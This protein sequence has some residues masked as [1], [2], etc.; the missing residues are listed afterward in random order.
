[1]GGSFSL[2]GQ[3]AIVTGASSGLGAMMAHGLA[4]AGCAVLL[5]ARRQNELAAWRPRSRR[6]RA[7]HRPS[8]RPARP[9][10][11]PGA[12][13]R[14][15]GAFGRLDGVVLN[16]ATSASPRP[17]RRTRRSFDDVMRVNVGAQ[18]A[19]AGAAARA[20]IG[21]GREDG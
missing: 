18:A 3:A 4:E 21:A 6:R 7:G 2:E 5:A 14:R 20:M 9:R 12:G 13:G 11:R 16:A 15:D 17:S 8:G 1:M 10:P 19:L